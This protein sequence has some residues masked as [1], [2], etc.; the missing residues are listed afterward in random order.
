M[1]WASAAFAN[2]T[3]S[4]AWRT[5]SGAIAL[6]LSSGSR[7]CEIDQRSRELYF[8]RR[9]QRIVL[10][11]GLLL[12]AHLAHGLRQSAGAAREC[13]LRVGG[14]ET[15]QGLPRFDELRVVGEHRYHR[16]GNLCGDHDL[17]AVDVGVVGALAL[18]EHEHPVDP[19]QHADHH[20]PAR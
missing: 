16:A 6:S 13:D 18:R 12:L 17:V 14:I 1:A 8:A 5:S 15:H 9:D 10:I 4:R 3:D 2:S 11:G 20:E 7:F 19:P